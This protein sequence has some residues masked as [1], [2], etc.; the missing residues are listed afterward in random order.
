MNTYKID[1]V[2]IRAEDCVDGV[3]VNPDL[4][5]AFDSTPNDER[6]HRETAFWWNRPFIRTDTLTLEPYESYVARFKAGGW[7]KDIVSPEEW[8]AKQEKQKA[9]WLQYFPAGTRYMVRCLDGGAWDRSTN[10]GRFPSLE[11]AISCTR[12]GPVYDQGMT[13][14]DKMERAK[15][16]AS[17]NPGQEIMVCLN[18]DEVFTAT[19]MAEED[20]FNCERKLREK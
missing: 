11:L 12:L 2:S 6:S 13:P 9:G 14:D 16:K 8:A 3:L 10:W 18:D 15:L 7:E 4:P 17:M 20:T 5:A 1:G 19:Y